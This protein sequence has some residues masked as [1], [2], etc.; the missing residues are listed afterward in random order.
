MLIVLLGYLK[1][2]YHGALV[3]SAAKSIVLLLF[4]SVRY[5]VNMAR[6]NYKVFDK[7]GH[8]YSGY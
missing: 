5:S 6:S 8:E 4:F 7:Y 3:K 2:W 1:T